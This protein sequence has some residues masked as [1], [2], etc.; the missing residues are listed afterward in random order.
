MV[1]LAAHGVGCGCHSSRTAQA[2]HFGTVSR[3]CEK[4]LTLDT[5]ASTDARRKGT[6]IFTGRYSENNP[7]SGSFYSGRV[8]R[9]LLAK[10]TEA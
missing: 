5:A 10:F 6:R 7:R 8:G 1:W 2:P 9:G 4:V 3:E